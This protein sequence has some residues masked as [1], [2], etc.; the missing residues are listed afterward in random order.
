MSVVLPCW[1]AGG[2]CAAT[3]GGSGRRGGRTDVLGQRA[4]VDDTGKTQRPP[5]GTAPFRQRE[6][7]RIGM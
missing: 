7:S 4:G 5:E 6:A 1:S 3:V 2:A